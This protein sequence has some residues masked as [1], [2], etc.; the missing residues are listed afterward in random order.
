ML[1]AVEE[2]R[3]IVIGIAGRIVLVHA[4]PRRVVHLWLVIIVIA[5][6]IV[7]ML[8]DALALDDA[9]RTLDVGVTLLVS[10][11]VRG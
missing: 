4:W 11:K 9:R 2:A 1:V 5:G 8:D 10:A 3:A 7:A 6:F